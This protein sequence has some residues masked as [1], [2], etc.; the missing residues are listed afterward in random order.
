LE[1][2]CR[3]D[4][5]AA[6][7]AMKDHD[8][9]VPIILTAGRSRRLPVPKALAE[10]AGKTA[11]AIAVENCEGLGTPLV[12][13]GCNAKRVRSAVPAEARAILN[14]DWRRGQL[15]SL[16]CALRHVPKKSAFLIYP[17]DQPLLKKENIQKLV[18]AFRARKSTQQ[19]VMPRYE[20]TDGHPVIISSAVRKEFF[21]AET[22][23][24]VVYR[25]PERIRTIKVDTSAVFE[26]F[27]S[28][29]T[30]RQ[31]LRK[32]LAREERWNEFS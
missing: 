21:Q 18:R 12:V 32:Y 29:K 14:R 28:S 2:A 27:N 9:I 22:A 31:C 3:L 25:R 7:A 20:R 17:V 24:E 8:K 16:Q 15:S 4:Y 5:S 26:D 10:F 1:F 6:A 23:R 30:Y 19:I 11:L 13:L